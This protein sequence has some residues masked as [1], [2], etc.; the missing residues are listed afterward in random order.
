MAGLNFSCRSQIK[1]AGLV[2]RRVGPVIVLNL[3]RC[4]G[5]M[6][7]VEVDMGVGI[8]RRISERGRTSALQRVMVA[9]RFRP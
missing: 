9:C 1:R 8:K 5:L 3:Q 4:I 6:E 2:S 7:R